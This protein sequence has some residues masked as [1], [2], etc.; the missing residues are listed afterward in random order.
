MRK[1]KFIAPF[2]VLAMMSSCIGKKVIDMSA[3][4]SYTLCKRGEQSPDDFEAFLFAFAESNEYSKYDRGQDAQKE[5]ESLSNAQ[6]ILD[7]TDGEIILVT[8]EKRSHLRVSIT[9]IALKGGLN[10]TF[11]FGPEARPADIDRILNEARAGFEVEAVEEG[12]SGSLAC[13]LR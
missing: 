11:R 1:L 3:R 13:G 12:V 5:L 4:E 10:L 2:F 8:I 6:V 9:N 7:D